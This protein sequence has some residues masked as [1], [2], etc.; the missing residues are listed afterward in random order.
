[1]FL[2]AFFKGFLKNIDFRSVALVTKKLWAILDFFFTDWTFFALYP[3][4]NFS[5]FHGISVKNES[6]RTKKST[7]CLGLISSFRY[8]VQD[9]S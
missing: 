9:L 6:A 2:H 5:K 8:S 3:T 4:L 1:M 7:A